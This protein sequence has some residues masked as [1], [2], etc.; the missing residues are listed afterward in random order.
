MDASRRA[1]ILDIVNKANPLSVAYH[2]R[3]HAF[4]LH[5][6]AARATFSRKPSRIFPRKS[7]LVPPRSPGRYG[8]DQTADSLKIYRRGSGL[9]L[10][11]LFKTLKF[12]IGQ[13]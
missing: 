5:R 6:G 10:K 9:L 4:E 7:P 2:R 3:A 1:C 8:H 13:I 11:I 12:S